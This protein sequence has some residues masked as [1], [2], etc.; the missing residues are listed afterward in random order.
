[1]ATE[2]S[3]GSLRVK[4]FSTTSYEKNQGVTLT[5]FAIKKLRMN[6]LN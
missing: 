6:V 1:M 4:L 3:S 5:E 2:I